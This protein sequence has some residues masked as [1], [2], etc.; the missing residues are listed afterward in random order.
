VQAKRDDIQAFR[1]LS[2]ALVFMFH[3]GYGFPNGYLGV[4]IFFALS[5]FVI[6]GLL[7]RLLTED[8][9]PLRAF[10]SGRV[11]RIMPAASTLIIVLS[12]V[13]VSFGSTQATVGIVIT[14]IYSIFSLGN[15]EIARQVGDYF[16]PEAT[17]N[18]FL[19]MW[20]LGK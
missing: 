15:I 10:Y 6:W 19:H 17:S 11:R 5:G 3:A 14:G 20:S 18:P 12:L 4:D 2:V 7:N 13:Q 8:K 1:A 9:H 16:S